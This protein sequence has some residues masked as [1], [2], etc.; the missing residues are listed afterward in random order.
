MKPIKNIIFFATALLMGLAACKDKLTEVRPETSLD[1]NVILADASSAYALYNGVYASLRGYQ[2][3]LFLL[4]EMRSEIWANGIFTESED[5][6]FR[7]FWAQDFSEANAPLSNWGGFYGLLNRVNTVITLFPKAPLDAATRDRYRGEMFGLR[8]YVYYNMLRTW[9]G[10]P[11]TTEPLKEIGDLSSL[12]K[13][14]ATPELIMQQIKADIDSSLALIGSTVSYATPSN[15]ANNKRVYWNRAATLTLKGDVYLWSGT[16][17]GGG[18]TDFATA[19]IALEEVGDNPLFALLPNYADIF[20]P[21]KENGNKEIIFALN[22]E[23][24]QANLSSYGNFLVN[25]TQ[26]STLIFNPE[27]PVSV[28]SAYPYVG[29]ANRVGLSPA[30]ITQLTSSTPS[31]SRVAA[32]FRTLHNNSAPYAL[33]GVILTKFLGRADPISSSQI[34]DTDF[35]IYRYADVLLLLAEAKAKLGESPKAE[36]DA[37]RK[38]AY[39][40]DFKP[41]TMASITENLNAILDEYQREFIG[42]GRYWWAERR[43]GDAY[44]YNRIDPKYLMPAQ[45]YKLLLP[46]SVSM[47][48]SDPKLK[49]TPGY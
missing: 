26:R 4:G 35:P 47:L 12:Y 41:F 17:Q 27:N 21:L 6:T 10:V 11:L 45:A 28:V 1:P 29:G 37:I 8:A 36:I 19:K 16:H 33:R 42:E 13:E 43:A 9:G 14:R 20:D 34:Y 24:D 44:V 46:I 23:K 48:N 15:P 7:Q 25:T 3:T 5:G 22:Y 2:G 18:N 39:G 31:D 49:Q 32:T 30:L 38:R 40:P